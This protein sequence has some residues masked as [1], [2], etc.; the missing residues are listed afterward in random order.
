MFA[1]VRLEEGEQGTHDGLRRRKAVVGPHR[2]HP[3]DQGVEVG[4]D[5]R[6]P[7]SHRRRRLREPIG[8]L[9]EK[10]VLPLEGSAAGQTPEEGA[11]QTVDVGADVH[12][13]SVLGLFGRHVIQRAQHG[14]GLGLPMPK[15]PGQSKIQQLGLTFRRHQNVGRLDVAV[16]E[17]LFVGLRQRR[18]HLMN[19]VASVVRFE[20]AAG[21]DQFFQILA[22]NV[23]HDEVMQH[24]AIGVRR[25]GLARFNRATMLGCCGCAMA[26]ISV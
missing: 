3:H 2:H 17:V 15:V 18:R 19:Q 4:G 10:V 21:V 11:A 6:P 5:F 8:Q 12:G 1:H 23:F 22:G 20:R 16:N 7:G 9:L 24:L 26:R 14:A 25:D 13:P